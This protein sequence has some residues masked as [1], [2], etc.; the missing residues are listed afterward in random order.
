MAWAMVNQWITTSV[1]PQQLIVCCLV[2]QSRPRNDIS[3]RE[4]VMN[5]TNVPQICPPVVR[6]SQHCVCSSL[7]VFFL[8]QVPPSV[9]VSHIFAFRFCHFKVSL[10]LD[11]WNYPIFCAE[12]SRICAP[13]L[14]MFSRLEFPIFSS[15]RCLK[16]YQDLVGASESEVVCQATLL[17]GEDEIE[18]WCKPL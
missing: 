10:S 8:Q 9:M 6:R 7:T 12:V 17:C 13:I 14:A 3:A 4:D 2:R 11:R 15:V 1:W 5:Q 18:L 16:L